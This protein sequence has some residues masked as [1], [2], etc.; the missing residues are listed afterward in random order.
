M[1]ILN[2]L[3]N[4]IYGDNKFENIITLVTVKFKTQL[5]FN[6]LFVGFY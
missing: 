5:F 2:V 6:I 3:K 4:I 1:W